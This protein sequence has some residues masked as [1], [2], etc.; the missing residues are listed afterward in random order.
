MTI[1]HIS[2]SFWGSWLGTKPWGPSIDVWHL[3]MAPM[4]NPGRW[5]P[6]KE[7]FQDASWWFVMMNRCWCCMMTCHDPW[8]LMTMN[9]HDSSW[10]IIRVNLYDTSWWLSMMMNHR[11]AS[12]WVIMMHH[13]TSSWWIVM[14]HRNEPSWWAMTIH[15]DEPWWLVMT[16][17]R[18]ASLNDS[19]QD[20]RGPL[21]AMGAINR[22]HT[23]VHG[24]HGICPSRYP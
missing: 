14:V 15:Q 1:D 23:F 19:F 12:W 10:W 24:A 6:W 17:H 3:W 22:C 21:F 9:H 2:F 20:C 4:A 5:Q 7:S 8:W 11:E 16:N 18:Q 13:D